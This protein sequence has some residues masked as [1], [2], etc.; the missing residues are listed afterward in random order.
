MDKI[1]AFERD[2]IKALLDMLLSDK[3]IT[4]RERKLIEEEY[5]VLNKKEIGLKKEKVLVLAYPGTG[6]TFL[7]DNYENV[8]DFEFQHYRYDYG[9]YKHLPLE[10]IKGNTDKRTNNPEWPNNFFEAL[11]NE[12]EKGRIVLVPFATSLLEVLDYLEEAKN[13]RVIFAIQDKNSFEQLAEK[14][15]QR[16][17]AEEF[18]ERRRAD[19]Q[20]CHDIIEKSKF[21]KVIIEPSQYLYDALVAIGIEFAIGK[22]VKNYF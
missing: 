9:I 1:D 11:T 5:W 8:S 4:S 21:E 13:V 10:Q 16:G 3:L 14:F 12:L 18:I 15:R 20:K 22:G 2:L 6:K 7:A 17:N 19:F